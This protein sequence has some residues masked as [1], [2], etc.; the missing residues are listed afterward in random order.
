[1][2]RHL[3][4]PIQHPPSQGRGGGSS[5]FQETRLFF[6]TP[7]PAVSRRCPCQMSSQPSQPIKAAH[8]SRPGWRLSRRRGGE[9]PPW[10]SGGKG[11]GTGAE[12]GHC[13]SWACTPRA[14]V[15][16]GFCLW[17]EG[18]SWKVQPILL[19]VVRPPGAKEGSRAGGGEGTSR[20]AWPQSL[21]SAR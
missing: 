14:E 2:F 20:G 19:L 8:P 17:G 5:F 12:P 4:G 9:Q 11:A 6:S 1:M 13:C 15:G 3:Q 18:G 7:P 10:G 21:Q 16:P